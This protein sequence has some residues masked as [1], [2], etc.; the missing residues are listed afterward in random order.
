MSKS[1]AGEAA[2]LNEAGD[3]SLS[4]DGRYVAFASNATNLVPG[5]DG[6]YPE[7]YV[8]DRVAGTIEFVSKTTTGGLSAGYHGTLRPS[9]SADGRFVV[10]ESDATSL[11]TDGVGGG[12]GLN[13]Y[14][15][16][17]RTGTTVLAD[18]SAT[19]APSSDSWIVSIDASGNHV[20][21]IT[22]GGLV[23]GDTDSLSDIYV[24]HLHSGT[25]E[26]VSMSTSGASGTGDT[27]PAPRNQCQ[28]PLRHLPVHGY[29]PCLEG[30]ERQD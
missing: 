5:V 29:G 10:F 19:G 26:R 2:N 30:Y 27:A 23:P 21:F 3:A 14:V 18:R 22:Y 24:R 8:R 11:T 15:R 20:A 16:D 17:R 6:G 28:R 9:I 1:A 12:S 25:T 13:I 4:R 7:I